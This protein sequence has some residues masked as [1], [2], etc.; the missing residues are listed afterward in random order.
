MQ[1]MVYHKSVYKYMISWIYGLWQN[2]GPVT[3]AL[4]FPFIWDFN[5]DAFVWI[6]SSGVKL[7]GLKYSSIPAFRDYN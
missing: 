4:F 6:F 5:I 2:A 1:S 3:G 7:P